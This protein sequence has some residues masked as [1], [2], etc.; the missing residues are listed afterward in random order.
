VTPDSLHDLFFA[1]AGAAA[2]L[3]GLLFV[4]ISIAHERLIG[5]DADEV[6]RVRARSALTAFTNAL[7]VSLFA[8]EPGSGLATSAISVSVAGLLFVIASV[9]SVRR[10]HREHAERAGG[11]RN[12]TFLI[13][14]FI[15]FAL[16]LFNG[17]RLQ[18]NPDLKGTADFLGTL[19]IIS[20]LLGIY[21]T[22][23]LIG[24]P[25]FALTREVRALAREQRHHDDDVDAE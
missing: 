11:V 12:L 14:I 1:A 2:A 4:A 22:W 18:I 21:R 19:V 25:D 23:E 10:H 3:I 15:V 13:A 8:L 24:G 16:Q 6:H 7:V 9:L 20:C 5:P 17:I